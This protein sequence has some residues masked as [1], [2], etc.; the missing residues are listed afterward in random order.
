MV[1]HRHM[2]RRLRSSALVAALMAIVAGASG[3]AQ[4]SAPAKFSAA[5]R[6]ALYGALQHDE[7]P[8]RVA[9]ATIDDET[10][11][12][13]V[14]RWAAK[15]L[16]QRVRPAEIDR[17]WAIE[18]A[19]VD[20]AAEFDR[21]RSEAR[22]DRWLV[23]ASNRDPCYERLM[24]AFHRYAE[25][26][27]GGGW[28]AMPA[29]KSLKPGERSATIAALRVRLAIEG[30]GSPTATDPQAFDQVLVDQVE[31]FQVT[32]G[33]TPDGIV[34]PTTR[35]ALDVPAEQRLEQIE[36]NL[37]RWRWLPRKPPTDRVVVDTGVAE[38]RFVH[39]ETDE[40]VMRAIVGKPATRTPIFASRLEAVIF[41][42][43]WNVPNEIA[44]K[45]ILPKAARQPGYLQSEGFVRTAQGLQ[46]RPGPKNALG[47]VKFDLDSPFGVY[48]HDTPGKAAFAGDNRALSHGCLRLEKPR[49]L[50][51]ALLAWSMDQV[52]AAIGQGETQ[53]T[54]IATPVALFVIHTTAFVDAKG[55]VNFRPDRYGW[56]HKLALALAGKDGLRAEAAP[57]ATDC[58]VLQS[59]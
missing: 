33:I 55:Q 41:N 14:L 16:G 5:E 9:L 34:G 51:A 19:R 21:A 27:S 4:V 31:A 53:R 30:Y 8:T 25:L 58:T 23:D 43:P 20:V 10:L 24:V 12:A 32:H 29:G 57:I 18:P 17:M 13:M 59:R 1:D 38:A 46:Q 56:D 6:S 22:L 39:H 35:T 44:T 42:P 15:E 26:V 50:A 2:S 54:K 28:K 47:R 49:E 45:E 37:E 40:L 36:A 11:R 3:N 48:L 52:D 7:E